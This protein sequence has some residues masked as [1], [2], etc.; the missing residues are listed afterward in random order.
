MVDYWTGIMIAKTYGIM[1]HQS[2]YNPFFISL[3][4]IFYT[5]IFILF[6]R[7]GRFKNFTLISL[8]IILLGYSL[9]LFGLSYNSELETGFLHVGIQGRYIFP[10]LGVFYALVVYLISRL[11]H[12]IIQRV[13]IGFTILVFFAAG[14][15]PFLLHFAKISATAMFL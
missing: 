4:R 3:M 1:G 7:I 2:Y 10:V 6:I 11:Q 13:M 14:P 15:V 5:V 9:V 8:L 12:L